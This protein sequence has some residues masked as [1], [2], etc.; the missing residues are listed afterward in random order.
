VAKL[1]SLRSHFVEYCIAHR[2]P[3]PSA[4]S[5]SKR[6]P[7]PVRPELVE[8]PVRCRGG[9]RRTTDRWPGAARRQVTFLVSPRKV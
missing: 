5:L 8:G 1:S 4:L 9:V 3:A 2:H 6:I 7:R